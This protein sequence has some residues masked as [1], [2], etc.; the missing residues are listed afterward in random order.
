MIKH[1]YNIEIAVLI[2]PPPIPTRLQ[3]SGRIPTGFPLEFHYYW[4]DISNHFDQFPLFINI[5]RSYSYLN[6]DCIIIKKRCCT[7]LMWLERGWEGVLGSDG[8]EWW[9]E[10]VGEWWG[11]STLPPPHMFWSALSGATIADQ[12]WS[13]LGIFFWSAL[14]SSEQFWSDFQIIEWLVQNYQC[15]DCWSVLNSSDQ[16]FK[17][18]STLYKIINFSHT[19]CDS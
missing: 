10:G 14:I 18:L 12:R 11:G 19:S 15:Q 9:R 17:P 6:T 3:E 4:H 7:S 8:V 13:V 5:L 1:W 16:T 2:T